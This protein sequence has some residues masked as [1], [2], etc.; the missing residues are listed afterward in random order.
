MQLEERRSQ[1]H[2]VGDWQAVHTRAI[3]TTTITGEEGEKEEVGPTASSRFSFL[4]SENARTCFALL[5]SGA[6]GKDG[7]Y[8]PS[9]FSLRIDDWFFE[10]RKPDANIFKSVCSTSD[11][12]TAMIRNMLIK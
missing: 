11:A 12:M 1:E 7:A 5:V 2:G 10:A 9:S 4:P 3:C 8:V 6:L